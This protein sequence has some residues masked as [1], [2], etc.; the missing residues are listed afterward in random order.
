M[1]NA[2][3]RSR[4][5]RGV[6][7][8]PETGP[9][10]VPALG[11]IMPSPPPKE[12]SYDPDVV[13]PVEAAPAAP[14]APV[15]EVVPE[16]APVPAAPVAPVEKRYEYQPKDE[17]G[18]PIGGI[19]VIKYTSEEDLREKL[20]NQNVELIRKLREVTRK[21]KLGIVDDEIP[22]DAEFA[23]VEQPKPR[24][25]S[26][27]ERFQISQ[28]IND[29][30]KS[31]DAV[32][33]LLEASV[34]YSTEQMRQI[35]SDMQFAKLQHQAFVNFQVFSQEEGGYLP[36]PEN[37]KI[38]TDW[39]FKKGLAPTVKNYHLAF[40]TLKGAGL[41]QE[42]PTVREVPQPPPAPA[43]APV[44]VQPAAPAAPVV[45]E[46]KPVV[47]AVNDSRIATPAPPQQ[48]RQP[49]RVPSGLNE[50]TSSASGATS[51]GISLTIAELEAMPADEMKKRLRTDPNFVALVNE[52]Y[53]PKP[54]T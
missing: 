33:K 49:V 35:Y 17:N 45:T 41:L 14:A 28:D 15:A 26:A 9:A 7:V 12:L 38:L 1:S 42:A 29:P 32:N 27:E 44:A 19:Q 3:L 46:P 39:M 21:Q 47:P 52:L 13:P 51:V 34:G 48:E 23:V 4:V 50:R 10:N 36:T 5:E 18:R 2:S 11:P 6:V 54:R 8:D 53:K 24:T 16:P 20:Q 22:S 37:T 31:V 40:S 43:P 30:E 25:L